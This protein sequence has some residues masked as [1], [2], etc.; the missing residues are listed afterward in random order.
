[1][2]DVTELSRALDECGDDNMEAALAVFEQRRLPDLRALVRI[3]QF[4][5]PYQVRA[6]NVVSGGA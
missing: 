5:A 2:E 1:M 3:M 4:G 6:H